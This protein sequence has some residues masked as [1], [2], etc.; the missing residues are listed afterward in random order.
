MKIRNLAEMKTIYCKGDC[1]WKKTR[2]P[3]KGPEKEPPIFD[4]FDAANA[5][6]I[7]GSPESQDVLR[8]K[9]D[10]DFGRLVNTEKCQNAFIIESRGVDLA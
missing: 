4:A 2:T 7:N 1:Q 5:Q 8:L 6:L 3:E 9:L 10:S